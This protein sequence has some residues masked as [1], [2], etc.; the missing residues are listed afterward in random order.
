MNQVTELTDLYRDEGGVD[1]GAVLGAVGDVVS[2]ALHLE[3]VDA[4]LVVEDGLGVGADEEE[5]VVDLDLGVA[6][7]GE[8]GRWG[9]RG[10]GRAGL[11]L[12]R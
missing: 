5:G 2:A 7:V 1:D 4:A 9:R 8:E 12:E 6:L 11:H 10:D 3:E